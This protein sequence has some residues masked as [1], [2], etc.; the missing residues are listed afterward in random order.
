MTTR[1]IIFLLALMWSAFA[2][3]GE[4]INEPEQSNQWLPVSSSISAD[5]T[6]EKKSVNKQS[7]ANA[8]KESATK[9]K[10]SRLGGM[11]DLLLPSGLRDNQ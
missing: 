11:F 2:A 7:S 1:F 10:R 8:K 6:Q 4:V 3:A 9:S 5:D